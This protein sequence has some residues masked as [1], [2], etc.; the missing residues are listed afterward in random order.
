MSPYPLSEHC[1]F[2]PL[3]ASLLAV[4]SGRS[5]NSA[6]WMGPSCPTPEV[7]CWSGGV[8]F[9]GRR[10]SSGRVRG[11]D[12]TC[13]RSAVRPLTPPYLLQ[14]DFPRRVG[15]VGGLVVRGHDDVATRSTST[16]SFFPPPGKTFSRCP[17]RVLEMRSCAQLLA[18][19]G[20]GL[21]GGSGTRIWDLAKRVN[22]GTNLGDLAERVNSGINYEDLA[23][24]VNSGIYLGDLA[25]RVNSGTNLGDL[26]ERVNSG[27]NP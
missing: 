11:V 1:W 5:R 15:H 22:S 4:V 9:E 26:V 3:C 14:T 6:R 27:T 25:K 23:E 13:V 19:G 16:I 21:R 10:L 8:W 7:G 24:R 20:V 17:T 18:C 12:L 2:R